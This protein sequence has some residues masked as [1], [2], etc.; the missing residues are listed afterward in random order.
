MRYAAKHPFENLTEAERS[1]DDR[2]GLYRSRFS[3]YSSGD[4]LTLFRFDMSLIRGQTLRLEKPENFR[5]VLIFP[6]FVD[7]YDR[8]AP[9]GA[10]PGHGSRDGLARLRPRLPGNDHVFTECRREGSFCRDEQD[11]AAGVED[12]GVQCVRRIQIMRLGDCDERSLPHLR[13]QR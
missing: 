2:I 9:G 11:R 1:H 13:G 8:D 10:Q 5:A 7:G 3:E 12:R 4:V 6:R